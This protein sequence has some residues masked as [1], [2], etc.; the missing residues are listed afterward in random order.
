MLVLVGLGN[1]GA[2]YQTTRHNAG[3]LL[4]EAVCRHYQMSVGV[5]RF[6]G[7][8][9]EGRVGSERLLWLLPETFMNL[10]GRSV[11]ELTRFYKITPEAV[12]VFHDDLDLA[13]GRVKI[14]VGGGNGG[15]NG[16]KSI[17]QELGS[18]GFV[19]VRIGIGRPPP[20]ADAAD[21]VLQSFTAAERLWLEQLQALFPVLMPRLLQGD[22][23]GVMNEISRSQ[24]LVM[25]LKDR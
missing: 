5:G 9:G 24:Q 7:R 13:P 2:R 15:H 1:P 17:Q 12:I 3:W 25:E 19:R 16:L 22:Y 11:A 23:S 6:Q 20:E 4:L 14:K 21:F 10:A 8:F 18:A